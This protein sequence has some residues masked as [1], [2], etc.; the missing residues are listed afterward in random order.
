M[1]CCWYCPAYSRAGQPLVTVV[2]SS[3]GPAKRRPIR[4]TLS[5]DHFRFHP[6]SSVGWMHYSRVTGACPSVVEKLPPGRKRSDTLQW[7]CVPSR[8]AW[9]ASLMM[10]ISSSAGMNWIDSKDP[11][12]ILTCNCWTLVGERRSACLYSWMAV[13]GW[14]RESSSWP[15]L[16]SDWIWPCRWTCG[17]LTP[18]PSSW[19]QAFNQWTAW[20]YWPCLPSKIP[21]LR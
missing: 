8:L 12:F 4:I 1:T 10:R 18:D 16:M 5:L 15:Q 17:S 13:R 20:S 6:Q 21:K 7:I 14:P 19:E 2:Y 9:M 3:P 11:L